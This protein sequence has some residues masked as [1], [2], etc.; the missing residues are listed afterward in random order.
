MYNKILDNSNGLIK[1]HELDIYREFFSYFFLL[2]YY[3]DPILNSFATEMPPG[4]KRDKAYMSI[5]NEDERYKALKDSIDDINSKKKNKRQK[6]QEDENINTE[7]YQNEVKQMYYDY[8]NILFVKSDK[9]IKKI[10]TLNVIYYLFKINTDIFNGKFNPNGLIDHL[11]LFYKYI[12]NTHDYKIRIPF[13]TLN[14]FISRIKLESLLCL[15][16]KS[17]NAL[18]I[19]S[20][21]TKRLNLSV[22]YKVTSVFAQLKDKAK[23]ILKGLKEVL[24]FE[25][26]K[27]INNMAGFLFET[28]NFL[29]IFLEKAESIYLDND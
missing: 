18:C 16:E 23:V 17:H 5:K 2:D 13:T 29:D 4:I 19:L 3:F 1:Q 9:T 12:H 20:I 11:Q 14:K 27:G 21:I 8:K 15:K 6:N 25:G 24:N 10:T 26:Y 28:G 22:Q 7:I